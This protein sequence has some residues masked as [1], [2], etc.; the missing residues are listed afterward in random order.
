MY[1]N[2][3][4][5]RT[6]H[7]CR[8]IAIYADLS[9]IETPQQE[10]IFILMNSI[11]GITHI[12]VTLVVTL[13][14]DTVR[15][16]ARFHPNIVRVFLFFISHSFVYSSS[17]LVI[18][19]FQNQI[20]EIE[21]LGKVSYTFLMIF[22][23][24]RVYHLY[25]CVFIFTAFCVER[26]L[27]TIYLEDYE[28]R[29]NPTASFLILTTVFVVSVALG[30]DTTYADPVMSIPVKVIAIAIVTFGSGLASLILQKHNLDHIKVM[31]KQIHR[32]RLSTRFQIVEN[33]RAFELLRNVA[34]V[35]TLG[36]SLAAVGLL[37]SLYILSDPAW[38]SIAG[39]IFDTLNAIVFAAVIILCCFSQPFWRDEFKAKL[40]NR[41][42]IIVHPSSE[43]IRDSYFADLSKA[44]NKQREWEC[45]PPG[46]IPPTRDS[47][48]YSSDRWTH[49]FT[50]ITLALTLFASL[51]IMISGGSRFSG[52][53]GLQLIYLLYE[54]T[55]FS[56]FFLILV[57]IAYY[58]YRTYYLQIQ[59]N[60]LRQQIYSK[61]LLDRAVAL[62]KLHREVNED[63]EM[64]KAA[65][66]KKKRQDEA[67][68]MHQKSIEEEEK[69]ENVSG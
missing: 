29:R 13:S 15:H 36:I 21:G 61:W 18:F 64:V 51:F 11:E 14:I 32:Y 3:N 16:C 19:F 39:V 2:C 50:L 49:S 9:V 44:W 17:R 8:F 24:L 22:S 46:R 53:D 60:Q 41:R 28:N 66:E 48:N 67:N 30:M 63:E 47:P 25:S 23:V 31:E 38:A 27:A 43:S 4:D 33:C 40:S 55:C 59:A 56:S 6:N 37:Y 42:P 52:R 1:H 5:N 69:F 54:I 10:F 34:I 20:V 58:G 26:F 35:S 45:R 62:Q 7:A 65:K 68:P 12:V 57:G